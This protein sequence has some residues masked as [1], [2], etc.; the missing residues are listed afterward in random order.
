M[1]QHPSSFSMA[2]KQEGSGWDTPAD[3]AAL[4]P[5][6]LVLGNRYK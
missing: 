6:A 4:Q 3:A 1:V 2:A 5:H